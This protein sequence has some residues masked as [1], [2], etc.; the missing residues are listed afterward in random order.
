MTAHVLKGHAQMTNSR[1]DA[2]HIQI[3]SPDQIDHLIARATTLNLPGRAELLR[4]VR[5]G[6]IYLVEVAR[7]APAPMRLI[8]R[9][10]RPVVLLFGDD[11]YAST[12]P[13]G[14]AAWQR[15]SYWARGAMIHATGADVP[16]YRMA[17]GLA[18]MTQR[19][20]LIE[21]D[22]A[23]AHDW[24]AVLYRRNIPAIGL[25][26]PDGQHPLPLRREAMQ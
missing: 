3:T 17:I 5:S 12:G 16:S 26:P 4:A 9:S 11:D 7:D 21:T 19:F 10:P 18:L 1:N 25:L 6:G 15:A 23:H 14:W 20:L 2:D 24:G 8:E 13:T 22:S